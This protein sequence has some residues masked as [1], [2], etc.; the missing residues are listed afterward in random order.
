MTSPRKQPTLQ[1]IVRTVAVPGKHPRPVSVRY[2]PALSEV[3]SWW[4]FCG[5]G[6]HAIRAAALDAGIA[7]VETIGPRGVC[8]AWRVIKGDLPQHDLG[9]RIDPLIAMQLVAHV[10]IP[11]AAAIAHQKYTPVA[12]PKRR[13]PESAARKLALTALP[14]SVTYEVAYEVVKMFELMDECADKR[15]H[16]RFWGIALGARCQGK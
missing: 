3:V 2:A 11:S 7:R 8:A 10:G 1:V 13:G 16:L 6:W 15:K 9:P 4:D 12:N 5:H 14:A